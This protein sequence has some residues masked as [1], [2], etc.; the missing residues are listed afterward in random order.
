MFALMFALAR[1]ASAA[2]VGAAVLFVVVAIDQAKYVKESDSFFIEKV[3]ANAPITPPTEATPPAD[4]EQPPVVMNLVPVG[5]D[6]RIR[7]NA[8]F[9]ERRF[10]LYYYTGFS[11]VGLAWFSSLFLR[12]RYLKASRWVLVMMFLSGA[13]GMMAY[14]WLKVYRPLRIM[15]FTIMDKPEVADDTGFQTLHQH[16]SMVNGAQ[17]LLTLLGSLFLC[18]PGTRP[19]APMVMMKRRPEE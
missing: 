10:R 7:L 3:P 8:Q 11:L 4:G 1:M 2:W 5:K 15:N 12:R 14:D 13:A 18:L 19:D 6:V 9:A 16:S 17:V